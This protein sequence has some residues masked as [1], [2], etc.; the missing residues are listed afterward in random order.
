MQ[1]LYYILKCYHFRMTTVSLFLSKL[2]ASL[3][4]Y[5]FPNRTSGV[6]LHTLSKLYYVPVGFV[7]NLFWGSVLLYLRSSKGD[8]CSIS[9]DVSCSWYI[10]TN[11]EETDKLEIKLSV[12]KISKSVTNLVR[13]YL[14]I[15]DREKRGIERKCSFINYFIVASVLWCGH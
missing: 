8:C 1:L 14:E 10:S 9:D 7:P 4:R 11:I 5:Y 13:S 3:M 12:Q 6:P 2:L 15:S